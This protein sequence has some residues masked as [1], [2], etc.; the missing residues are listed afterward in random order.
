[1][2]KRSIRGKRLILSKSVSKQAI[3]RRTTG[4]PFLP[5]SWRIHIVN[6]RR[7]RTSI[8]VWTSLP[9]CVFT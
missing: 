1:K 9:Q 3:H 7:K 4:K 6:L 5:K 2:T 8:E